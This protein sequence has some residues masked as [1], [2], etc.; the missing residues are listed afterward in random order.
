MHED[1]HTR[2]SAGWGGL[3]RDLKNRLEYQVPLEMLMV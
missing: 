2:G 3:D 1:E